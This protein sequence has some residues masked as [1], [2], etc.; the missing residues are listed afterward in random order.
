MKSFIVA[1]GFDVAVLC[2]NYSTCVWWHDRT[3]E[4]FSASNTVSVLH[5]IKVS[6]VS[7]N[8]AEDINAKHLSWKTIFRNKTKTPQL[9]LQY[10]LLLEGIAKQRRAE[11]AIRPAKSLGEL[12]WRR[13]ND[14]TIDQ[15]IS[16]DLSRDSLA[17]SRDYAALSRDYAALSRD[18][19]ALSRDY[20]AISR[21]HSALSRDYA[22]LSR[23]YAALSRDLDNHVKFKQKSKRQNYLILKKSAPV[24]SALLTVATS[25]KLW[26]GNWF[27]IKKSLF[28]TRFRTRKCW[29]STRK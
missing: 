1:R 5:R 14:S 9:V 4:N 23:A 8:D 3:L 29:S 10:V 24:L 7:H 16:R 12:K 18:Y 15:G 22:T 28:F 2:Q 17:L 20:A 26:V 19:S 6:N 25:C 21:D 13:N 11:S 27:L